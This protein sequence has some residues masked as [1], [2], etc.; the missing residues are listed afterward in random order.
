MVFLPFFCGQYKVQIKFDIYI[1]FLARKYMVLCY[2]LT[3]NFERYA[4]RLKNIISKPFHFCTEISL[5]QNF[6]FHIVVVSVDVIS[7]W[8][9]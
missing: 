8:K 7:V 4:S 9:D 3:N 5:K 2:H 6:M 1:V